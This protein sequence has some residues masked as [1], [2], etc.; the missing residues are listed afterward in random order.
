LVF[1][2]AA[3]AAAAV[4]SPSKAA[5]RRKRGAAQGYTAHGDAGSDTSNAITV[6]CSLFCELNSIGGP[7]CLFSLLNE[8]EQHGA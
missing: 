7:P 4:Y 8:A 1:G 3:A 6:V 2:A 5:R